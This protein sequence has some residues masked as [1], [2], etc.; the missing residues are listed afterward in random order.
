[1]K[2]ILILITIIVLSCSIND[3]EF[4]LIRKQIVLIEKDT[5]LNNISYIPLR[6]DEYKENSKSKTLEFIVRKR[7]TEGYGIIQTKPELKIFK[8][9]STDS[10]EFNTISIYKDL[11][12]S[13]LYKY[14]E[15]TK[16]ITFYEGKKIIIFKGNLPESDKELEQKGVK[17]KDFNKWKMTS[18]KIR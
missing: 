10:I 1:M 14:K 17:I 8:N 13:Y 18:E 16:I 5:L 2:Y 11:N 6:E 7:Y 4:T 3:D 12:C 9:F 15:F